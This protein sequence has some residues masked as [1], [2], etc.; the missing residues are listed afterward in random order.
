MNLNLYHYQ[1]YFNYYFGYCFSLQIV[2]PRFG[3]ILIRVL[4][5]LIVLRQNY[6]NLLMHLIV[7]FS[8]YL[9]YYSIDVIH[10]AIT[11][12]IIELFLMIFQSS[13][14]HLII[15]I[16]KCF[17]SSNSTKCFLSSNSTKCFL[18][19]NSTK[20]FLGSNSTKCFLDSNSTKCFL[21]SNSTKCFLGS[22]STKCFL[23]SNSTIDLNSTIGYQ[24]FHFRTIH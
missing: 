2:K 3:V 11:A 4:K 10:S 17:L 9:L 13:M 23:G 16:T 22:N 6:C 18:D 14:N 24:L 20:C 21:G 1:N 19:S 5:I 12:I 7:L 15:N 8:R